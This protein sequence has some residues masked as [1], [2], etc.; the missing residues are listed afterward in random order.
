M[1]CYI[2][3]LKSKLGNGKQKLVIHSLISITA[4]ARKSTFNEN[5]Q[6]T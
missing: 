4:G 5:W 3:S 2:V 1:L 6:S